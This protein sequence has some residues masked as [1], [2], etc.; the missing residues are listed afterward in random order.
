MDSKK[1]CSMPCINNKSI[2]I[3]EP[4]HT[5]PS[6]FKFHEDN[7]RALY[8]AMIGNTQYKT[9]VENNYKIAIVGLSPAD[10]QLKKFTNKYNRTKSY[11]NSALEAA[12]EGLEKDLAKMLN[13]LG[14][15]K[16]LGLEPLPEN[17]DLNKCGLFLTTSLVKCASL[18][19]QGS[20][21]DFSPWEYESNIK[22]IKDRFIPE[23]LSN[24]SISHV[25][26]LGS[27]AKKTL[28]EKI[29]IDGISAHEYIEKNNKTIA[30]LPHPSGANRES[31]SLASLDEENFPTKQQHQERMWNK[32]KSKKI[33]KGKSLG[34]EQS[35]KNTRGSRWQAISDIR[36]IFQI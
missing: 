4:G 2:L 14:V 19:L 26:I 9:P 21:S 27:K 17:I 15:T 10:T 16:K 20:S 23:I 29:H 1:F 33:A 5:E 18:T 12:F 36:K 25:L 31:V 6:D 24:K 35:Y 28:T 34:N 13:G 3:P 22:C 30:Y 11:E 8:I 7:D 32:Y